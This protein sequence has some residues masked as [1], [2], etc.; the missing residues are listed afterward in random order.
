M[1]EEQLTGVEEA[2]DAGEQEEMD[3]FATDEPGEEQEAAAEPAGEENVGDDRVEKAFAKRLAADREKMREELRKEIAEELRKEFTQQKPQYQPQALMREDAE[4]LA[5]QYN[6][7]VEMVYA[8]YNQQLLIDQQKQSN[9]TLQQQL[10]KLSE[11]LTKNEAFRELERMRATNPDLPE[12][13]ERKLA[14]IRK[15]YQSKYGYDLPWE[16]AY[17][18]Q[19]ADEAM[20]GNL[21]KKVEQ[22]TIAKIT[23]RD[24][25]TIQA[26]KGGQ[27]KKPDIWELPKDEFERLVEEAKAGKYKK[28]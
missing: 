22:K 15:D 5:D 1:L 24:K 26:G 18:R 4:K 17:K 27:A 13:D 16:E 8:M 20:T 19:I 9:A 14:A 3:I 25:A 2:S 7:S 21:T 12:V 28:S 6:T 11:H 23:S 10:G